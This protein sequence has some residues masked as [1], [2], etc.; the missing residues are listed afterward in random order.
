MGHFQPLF[1]YFVFEMQLLCK[2]SLMTGFEPW[3]PGFGIDRSA[4]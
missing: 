1:V 2:N 4:N 3:T